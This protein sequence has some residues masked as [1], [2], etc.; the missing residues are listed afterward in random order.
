MHAFMEVMYFGAA[1]DE[2]INKQKENFRE[3]EAL[4]E[5]KITTGEYDGQLY[6]GLWDLKA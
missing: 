1:D 3:Q 2:Q 6:V 4:S 5:E